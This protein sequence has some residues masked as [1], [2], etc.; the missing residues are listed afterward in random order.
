MGEFTMD[1]NTKSDKRRAAQRRANER[2]LRDAADL[3][4]VEEIKILISLKINPNAQD[5]VSIA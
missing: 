5:E 2:K 4:N 3:N 1:T